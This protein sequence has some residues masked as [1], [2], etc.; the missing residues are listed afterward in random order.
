MQSYSPGAGRS[1]R[2]EHAVIA[3]QVRARRRHEHSEPAQQ[4]GRLEDQRVPAHSERAL[5]VI[6]EPAVRKL[7]EAILRERRAGG[8]AAQMRQALAV[9]G[10]QVHPGV[11]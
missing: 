3:D 2:T 11:E 7:G 1:G 9:V 10:V 5:Q 4:L 8:I 6:G